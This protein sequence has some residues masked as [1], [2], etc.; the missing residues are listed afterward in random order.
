MVA[1]PAA[2]QPMAP[3]TSKVHEMGPEPSAPAPLTRVDDEPYRLAMFSSAS[4]FTMSGPAV[5]GATVFSMWR[6]LPSGAM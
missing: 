2:R 5:A 1:S 6:I 3:S 4:F